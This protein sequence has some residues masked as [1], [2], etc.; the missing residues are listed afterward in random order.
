MGKYDQL[1]A[2]LPQKPPFLFVDE[3]SEWEPFQRVRGLARFPEGH[4]IFT[5]HLPS[6][7]LVPGVILIE[8]L[9]QLAGLALVAEAGQPIRG[10]LGEVVRARFRRTVGPDATVELEARLVQRFGLAAR[11]EV[12]AE[13]DGAIVVDGEI[14][15]VGAKG[16]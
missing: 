13:V 6:E 1:I 4:P 10:Y 15:L 14:V 11:F 7:P 12:A 8:A 2:S 5:N 3:V 9:A 16:S